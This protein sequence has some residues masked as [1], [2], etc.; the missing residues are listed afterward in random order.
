[1]RFGRIA[2][3]AAYAGGSAPSAI[4]WR[5]VES[6]GADVVGSGLELGVN[7]GGLMCF[8]GVEIG[9]LSCAAGRMCLKEKREPEVRVGDWGLK[10][11]WSLG[12]GKHACSLS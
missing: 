7:R 4:S 9:S 10:I 6:K 2:G 5:I 3:R 12:C 11:M 1:M 8:F